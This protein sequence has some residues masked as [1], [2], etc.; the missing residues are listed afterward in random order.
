MVEYQRRSR[1]RAKKSSRRALWVWVREAC[2]VT[3]KAKA[4]W[5]RWREREAVLPFS[6]LSS[7]DLLLGDMMARTVEDNL[8]AECVAG[9]VTGLVSGCGEHGSLC[10]SREVGIAVQDS[11]RQLAG[12]QCVSRDI[13][14]GVQARLAAQ[15]FHCDICRNAR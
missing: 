9:E 12:D 1:S 15:T 4:S 5:M 11:G 14:A 13:H 3:R 8:D 2:S 7:V 10:I 6:L